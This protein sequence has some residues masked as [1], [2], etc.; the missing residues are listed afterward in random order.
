MNKSV[1]PLAN[2]PVK[3]SSE[4]KIGV[5]LIKSGKIT[6]DDAREVVALSKTDGLLFGDAAVKLGLVTNADI[7]EV[8]AKQFDYTHLVESSNFSPHLISAFHPNSPEAEF[9]RGL[10]TQ[11]SL[12]WFKDEKNKTLAISSIN[13][14]SGNSRFIANLAISF[15]QLG[16]KTILI[17]ANLRN[18]TQ[19]TIF[20][21]NLQQ[22]GLSDILIARAGLEAIHNIHAISK[23]SLLPSGAVPPNPQELVSGSAFKEVITF[24]HEIFDIILIDTPAFSVGADAQAIAA[25]AGGVFLVARKN[26]TRTADMN[27]VAKT[28]VSNGT[29]VV[30]SVITDF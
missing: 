16:K 17:D 20:D 27:K 2:P 1:S 8:L 15:S 4:F 22:R 28:L 30:G 19:H 9:I 10:R 25:S 29:Q 23:L 7:Q 11:L 21:L 3:Q 24:L 5:L 13:E 14:G 6:A 18:P 26:I 12:D